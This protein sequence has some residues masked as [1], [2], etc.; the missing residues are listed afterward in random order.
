MCGQ[1]L[2]GFLTRACH[3]GLQSLEWTGVAMKL[4]RYHRF[5][6][7]LPCVACRLGGSVCQELLFPAL[8]PPLAIFRLS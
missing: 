5:S 3:T 6:P 2:L 7:L 8:G 1:V 4:A